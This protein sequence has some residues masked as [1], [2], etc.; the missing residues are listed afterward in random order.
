MI[1]PHAANTP[2]FTIRISK[3]IIL[4]ISLLLV[5]TMAFSIFAFADKRYSDPQIA[6]LDRQVQMQ[7]DVLDQFVRNAGKLDSGMR[8]FVGNLR[9]ITQTTSG[10][11]LSRMRLFSGLTPY[12]NGRSELEQ[13]TGSFVK[14]IRLLDS[15]NFNILRAAQ[16]LD[17]VQ[18]LLLSLRPH[19]R[20]QF[21]RHRERAPVGNGPAFWP[22]DNGGTITS[23]FGDRLNFDAGRFTR[24]NGVDIG[25]TH[26]SII[27][28]TA[29]GEV[30]RVDYE[31]RGYGL[32]IE[33]KHDDGFISRYAHLDK[34]EV[35]KGD[36][37]YQ[38]Q[39]V[40]RMG[41]TG[42]ATGDHVHYEVMQDGNFLDP[43]GF[44]GNKFTPANLP[45]P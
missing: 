39:I 35:F 34:Q 45:Q 15:I 27:R 44:M 2:V 8:D 11:P 14:E 33:V 20:F 24:H 1:V 31:P 4:F 40:G 3:Y 18:N 22:V 30:I 5:I 17:R 43:T 41:R 38:G 42:L 28:A 16:Q 36:L 10:L 13:N 23:P 9:S 26:G 7:E 37:V 12:P 32:Y 6:M 19:V 29:P 25:N 21:F